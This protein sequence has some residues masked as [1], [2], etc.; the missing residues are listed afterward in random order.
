MLFV[1]N[2]IDR[3]SMR[4]DLLEKLYQDKKDYEVS[5]EFIDNLIDFEEGLIKDMS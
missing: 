1:G 3:I 4:R 5:D 2:Q